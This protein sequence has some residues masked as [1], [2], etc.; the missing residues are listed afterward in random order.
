MDLINSEQYMTVIL[1][2][3]LSIMG[4]KSIQTEHKQNEKDSSANYFNLW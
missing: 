2:I 3:E 1:Y 4:T